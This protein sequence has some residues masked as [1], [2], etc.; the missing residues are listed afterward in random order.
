VLKDLKLRLD[1]QKDASLY[2]R[3]RLL[4][5]P[6][7]PSQVIN[8]QKLV[9][10]CSNDYLGLA[11]HPQVIE[12]FIQ[13]ARKHGVGSGASHLVNGHHQAHHSLEE[14]LADF[15]GYPSVILYSTGYMANTG[16]IH[17]L[18]E[19]GS[20]LLEDRLNHASLLDGGLSSAASFTRYRHLDYDHLEQLLLKENKPSMVVTDGVFSMDGDQAD[21]QTLSKVS[22]KHGA[23]LMVDDAHGIGICGPQ[24]RGSVAQFGLDSDAVQV[25]VG[26]MGKA[27]GTFGAF[28][29]G[30]TELTD[31]LVQFSRP[32]IYTTALPP[33][34]AEASR[35]SLG[36]I[37]QADDL[38]NRLVGLQS[39]FRTEVL[40]MGFQLWNSVSPIQP[41]MV[42]SSETAI[43]LSAALEQ[44]GLLV[45]AIRPPTVP[46]N[47]ARLRVTFSASHT[48]EQLDQLLQAL[49]ELR[50]MVEKNE[51][52]Q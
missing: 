48:E 7:S 16:S 22:K 3:R 45:T 20:R 5:S 43:Q 44:K 18:M 29:A 27:F 23:W 24:G 6:Q 41:I 32:Y 17:A 40:S 31:S 13:G 34:I 42:G 8:N 38:R 2:R 52:Y 47:S 10:F 33:A 50:H 35:V 1:K 21:L 30:S 51:P 4:Q 39:R 28:V 37:R 14:E 15:L 36:L 26:T 12:A 11:N 49:F 19:K 25:L 46:A 9:S